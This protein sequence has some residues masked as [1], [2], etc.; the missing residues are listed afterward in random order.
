MNLIDRVL[1]RV[2]VTDDGLGANW[3]PLERIVHN[4]HMK[5]LWSKMMPVCNKKYTSFML[6]IIDLV[7]IKLNIFLIIFFHFKGL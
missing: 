2:G 5:D 4:F 6:K 1:T 3:T 7:Q